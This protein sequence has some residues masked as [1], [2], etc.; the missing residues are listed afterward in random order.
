M[1]KQFKIRDINKNDYLHKKVF[2]LHDGCMELLELFVRK[3]VEAGASEEKLISVF[4]GKKSDW[5]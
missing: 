4:E 5:L 2:V 1:I 3:A